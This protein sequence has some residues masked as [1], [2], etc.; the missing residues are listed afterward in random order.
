MRKSEGGGKWRGATNDKGRRGCLKA[1]ACRLMHPFHAEVVCSL[2]TCIM[3]RMQRSGSGSSE[4]ISLAAACS[5]C[6]RV[7]S[8]A[9]AMAATLAGRGG[10]GEGGDQGRVLAAREKAM[11]KAFQSAQQWR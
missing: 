7:G 8:P 11:A 6:E 9:L 1:C 2:L 5:T 10:G 3:V 4:Q